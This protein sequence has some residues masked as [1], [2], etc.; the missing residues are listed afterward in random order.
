MTA[1]SDIVLE[2]RN[3]SLFLRQDGGELKVVDDVSFRVA[4]GEFFALIGESGSGKTTIAKAVMRLLPPGKLR[5]AGSLL[6]TGTDVAQA[7]E[8]AMRKLRGQAM[9]M[10]FQEPMTSL[11]P[12]MTVAAQIDEALQTH[13]SASR[14][15]RRERI[16]QLLADVRFDN[17]G[18]VA[19]QYPHELSGGMRQRVMIAIALANDPLLL[20]ADEPT[21]ALDVTIQQEVLEILVRLQEKYRLSVFFISHDLALVNRFANRVGVLYGGMLMESGPTA[22]VIGRPA[23]PYTGALLA[24]MPRLREGAA[25]QAGI[26]GNV[27]RVDHWFDGCRFAQRC[28]H[29]HPECRSARIDTSAASPTQSV[30]CLHPLS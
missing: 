10:I 5:I 16:M 28:T 7:P 23:H 2:A 8:R 11:N 14:S 30:R 6:V 18:K 22:D 15:A 9:S 3:L 27:P 29:V 20:I 12:I 1:D 13:Q 17:P 4:R 26:E 21:T 19:A 25:R 24:C